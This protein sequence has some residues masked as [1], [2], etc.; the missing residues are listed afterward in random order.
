M[1]IGTKTQQEAMLRKPILMPPGL[2]KKV[3]RIASQ[4]KVSF[5]RVVRDAVEA[6]DGDLSTED[7]MLLETLTDTMI[8]TT[9][10]VVKKI[11]AVETR[12]DETHAM[13]EKK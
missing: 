7:E 6:F 10:E 11:E 2:I 9:H 13:L 5:A 12:L 8:K 3:D 1:A 4:K